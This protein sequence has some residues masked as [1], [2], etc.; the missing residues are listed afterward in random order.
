[1]QGV[2]PLQNALPPPFFGLRQTGRS[3]CR[4]GRTNSRNILEDPGVAQWWTL[5]LDTEFGQPSWRKDVF[6]GIFYNLR[7]V[8]ML[9]SAKGEL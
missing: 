7:Q 8:G 4:L 6:L 2:S 9:L 3:P 5:M 1:M